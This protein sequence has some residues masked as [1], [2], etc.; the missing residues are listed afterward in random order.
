M[1]IKTLLFL[2]FHTTFAFQSCNIQKSTKE[3]PADLT[4]AY[5]ISQTDNKDINNVKID[6]FQTSLSDFISAKDKTY[7]D[8]IIP[9][10]EDFW[11]NLSQDIEKDYEKIKQDTD[12]D[13]YLNAEQAKEYGLV[14][15][16]LAS[17]SE[18]E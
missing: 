16:V 10:E 1:H 5:T 14:D 7:F 17:L 4:E 18:K 2:L 8:T 15:E 13:Y 12:R 3:I 6:T 9:I 11:T